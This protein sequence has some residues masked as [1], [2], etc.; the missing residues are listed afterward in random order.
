MPFGRNT[1]RT[2]NNPVVIGICF[3]TERRIILLWLRSPNPEGTP[4]WRLWRSH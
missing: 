2:P 3:N 4:H 1:E